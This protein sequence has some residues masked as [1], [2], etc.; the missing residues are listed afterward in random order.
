MEVNYDVVI[1]TI[2]R[3]CL[4]PMLDSLFAGS[5]PLPGQVF[6][7]DDRKD[8][9]GLLTRR[10]L[11]DMVRVLHSGGRGPAAA[12]NL[13][14]RASGARWIAFLDDDVLVTDNWRAQLAQDLQACDDQVG[15]TQG[16][17][18]VPLPDD[19]P[20]TDWERNVKGLETAAWATA[21]MAYRRRALLSVDG[22]D[23]RFPRAYRED[24]DLAIRTKE[25]G[26]KLVQGKRH[27]V[28][29][30]RP[31]DAWVSVRLQKGNA[32]DILMRA[33]HGKK[34]REKAQIPA[35][36]RRQHL[37]TT[38]MGICALSAAAAGYRRLA[39]TG[40]I[41]WV[42]ATAEFAW[43]RIIPGPRTA[44]EVK[45]MALTSVAIPAVATYQLLQG[46]V[47]VN[48]K[49][50][51]ESRHKPKA[52]LFDRDGTLVVDVPYNGDPD[53]VSPVPGAF[54]AVQR[55][56]EAGVPMAVV[57]NQ[58][59]IG[60]GLLSEDQVHRVNERIEE[61]LGPIGPFLMCP[62]AP[63]QECQCRKPQPGMVIE[64]ARHLG[65]D[66]GEVVLIGDI[67]AD[68]E[69]ARAVGARAILVPTA[70]T[71]PEEIDAASEVAVDLTSAID[72]AMSP[73]R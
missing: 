57:T 27:T 15:A 73:P 71:R 31:A 32:D 9:S 16:R 55:L 36:R 4:E 63:E 28:H 44:D 20:A 12:R 3:P 49:L 5:G 61:M 56:R 35:G 65:V 7:V 48:A 58:S 17:L 42:A 50:R 53:L 69:A 72:L 25:A 29:P 30:V 52:V 45:K 23:E 68:M 54:R 38:A 66:P 24:A 64:A 67:G 26:W 47:Q 2:G 33:L 60:R 41:G 18:Y 21:D 43:R 6:L 10:A 22:F 8:P 1:P 46:V 62:H 40:F 11:P 14:W 39:V 70:E 19:R 37:F 34:W 13:G 59:G 51:S